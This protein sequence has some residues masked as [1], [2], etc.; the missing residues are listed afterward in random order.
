MNSIKKKHLIQM[1]PNTIAGSVLVW[2]QADCI[3]VGGGLRSRSYQ[4]TQ[5]IRFK[6]TKEE[7]AGM[8]KT[9]ANC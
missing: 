5:R 6:S 1:W 4:N 7:D 2:N 3:T 8:A 9:S